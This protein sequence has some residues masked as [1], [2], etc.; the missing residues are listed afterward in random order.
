MYDRIE[1]KFKTELK[2][3]LRANQDKTEYDF[4]I[5]E[6][7]L[8]KKKKEELEC[9]LGELTTEKWK[10]ENP[11]YKKFKEASPELMREWFERRV[12]NQKQIIQKEIDLV[13]YY[14]VDYGIRL[15]RLPIPKTEIIDLSNSNGTEKI[16]FLEKLGVLDY[17]KNKEPFNRSTNALASVIS[18]FTGIDS[19]TVQSYINPINNPTV[20]QKN[21]PLNSKKTVQRV[22]QK[23]LNIG[24][25]TLN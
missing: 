20:I 1:W 17:L 9:Q 5:Y 6:M 8:F 23:L 4:L 2:R 11:E 14:I 19:K 12:M 21:N 22:N 25:K 3:F 13:Q 10:K 16:I 7:D 15:N 18:G 24:F